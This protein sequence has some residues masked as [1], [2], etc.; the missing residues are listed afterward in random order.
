MLIWNHGSYYETFTAR[1]EL[2][3]VLF[4]GAVSLWFFVCVRNFSGTA[5]HICAKFTRKT[6]LLHRCD[7]FEGQG[8]RLRSS[9]TNMAF[10]ALSALSAACVWFMHLVKHL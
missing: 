6:C 1:S 2:R 9:G 5:E 7:E 3:K 10:S 8:Q 4:F